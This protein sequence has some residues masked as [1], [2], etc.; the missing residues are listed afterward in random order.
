V[1]ARRRPSARAAALPARRGLPDVGR[2]SPPSGRSVLVGLALFALAAGAY[3]VARQSS[4]FALRTLDIR[5]GTP[6]VRAE[7]RAALAGEVGTSLLRVDGGDLAGRL[8]G[9][10]DVLSFRYDR[11]FPHTLRVTIRR[12]Q[13]VLV[14]RRQPDSFLVSATG[15]VLRKL[16]HPRLSSLPR[17][18]VPKTT[19]IAVGD[20]LSAD[21]GAAAAAAI[22]A[23]HKEPLPQA[24]HVVTGGQEGLALHLSSGLELRLGDPGD[25]RLKLAI[26]GRILASDAAQGVTSGYLDVS[27]PERPVLDS[28]SQVEG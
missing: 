22:A 4:L 23:L 21:D 16:P 19:Q 14:L 13:P 10:P 6:A 18:W 8:A 7:V 17:F 26:A 25:L 20:D 28:N 12:E 27:V 24:V 1:A 9:V 15:R 3:V 2:F 11:R 5:G